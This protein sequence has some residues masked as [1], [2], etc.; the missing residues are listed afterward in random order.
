[1]LNTI[2][3]ID[4]DYIDDDD[5]KMDA[6][7]EKEFQE[8]LHDEER[9]NRNY[10]FYLSFNTID[11]DIDDDIEMDAKTEKEFQESINDEERARKN[12]EFYLSFN[13]NVILIKQEQ[14]QEKVIKTLNIK[15]V[16]KDKTEEIFNGILPI[17]I[18]TLAGYPGVGK[19]FVSIYIAMIFAMQNPDKRVL[20]WLSEDSNIQI[21]KRIEY[22]ENRYG[23]KNINNIDFCFDIALPVLSKEF[24]KFTESK[25]LKDIKDTIKNYNLVILDPLVDFT[26]NISENQNSE[27]AD[28]M[29]IFKAIAK[30]N[31]ISI[32]FIHHITKE[33]IKNIELKSIIAKKLSQKE[34]NDRLKKVR[35]ASAIA[36]SSRMILFA[37]TNPA[38]DDERIVS[39]VKSNVSGDGYIVYKIQLPSLPEGAYEDEKEFLKIGK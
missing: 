25:Y 12:L 6:K 22:I 16:L 26:A 9:A 11:I 5:I 30:E 31:N 7:T 13:P 33:E 27:I 37:E 29:L 8:S 19:T 23:F 24:G 3:C 17:G 34:V 32:L 39:I 15:D 14:K 1:M 18:S 38:Q 20:L 35:G 4:I 10:E 28:F 21:R 2:D 36:G